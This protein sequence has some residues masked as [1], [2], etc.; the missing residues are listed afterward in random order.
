M[1]KE[2]TT[3]RYLNFLSNLAGRQRGFPSLN[4]VVAK[5]RIS[6]HA[7]TVLKNRNLMAQ[8]NNGIWKWSGPTPN[9]QMATAVVNEVNSIITGYVQRKKN[10]GVAATKTHTRRAPSAPVG[11]RTQK[12]ACSDTFSISSLKSEKEKLEA[13]IAKIDSVLEVVTEFQGSN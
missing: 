1:K 10:A 12:K 8:K 9:P 5:N 6:S 3:D 7:V 2:S 13:R 4:K 11:V